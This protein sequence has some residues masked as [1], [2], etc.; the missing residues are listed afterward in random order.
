MILPNTWLGC[1]PNSASIIPALTEVRKARRS[2]KR[3]V[4]HKSCRENH[5]VVANW[6]TGSP[7]NQET[8]TCSTHISICGPQRNYQGIRLEVVEQEAGSRL[9]K[10]GGDPL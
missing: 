5:V 8:G 9:H 4:A 1:L 3:R 10:E 2:G 6:T 7:C